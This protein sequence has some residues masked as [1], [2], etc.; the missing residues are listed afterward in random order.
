M[1]EYLS[2][3]WIS[4]L[5]RALAASAGLGALAPLVVD[6][7]VTGVPGR[8]DV[9]YRISVDGDGAGARPVH[10]SARDGA[11]PADI[12]LTTDYATAVA[13]ARGAQNAQ[14]ALA[15]GRLRIGGNLEAVATYGRVLVAL[16]DVAGELRDATTFPAP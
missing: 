13:I 5:D 2:D 9:R 12:R 11:P 8:G 4:A 15:Q 10:G 3:D 6:Q 1:P 7:V 14:I 16:G